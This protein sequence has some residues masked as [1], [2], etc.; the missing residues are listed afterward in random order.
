[1]TAKHLEHAKKHIHLLQLDREHMSKENMLTILRGAGLN[2]TMGSLEDTIEEMALAA[3][4]T[5]SLKDL[6]Q[7]WGNYLD[8]AIEEKL[9]SQ[10]FNFFDRDGNG[11]ISLDE[12]HEVMT[13]LGDKLTEEECRLFVTLV[14]QNGDGF[15]QYEEFLSA[16]RRDGDQIGLDQRPASVDLYLPRNSPIPDINLQMT[17]QK[18]ATPATPTTP[19]TQSLRNTPVARGMTVL[20]TG[21]MPGTPPMPAVADPLPPPP[22]LPGTPFMGKIGNPTSGDEVEA[23]NSRGLYPQKMELASENSEQTIHA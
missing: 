16:L 22:E 18:I 13:E 20:F 3:Q 8:N 1:M 9:L 5:W 4:E 11:V 2:P 7:I 12:F 23:V 17:P 19:A 14:D 6:L 10:A 15:M 21:P